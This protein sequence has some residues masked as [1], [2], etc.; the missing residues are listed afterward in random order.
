MRLIAWGAVLG[1]VGR[2]LAAL[3]A[4]ALLVWFDWH[5]G[6]ANVAA[7]VNR[8]LMIAVVALLAAAPWIARPFLGPVAP[9]RT[10]RLIRAGGY[11]MVY[12]LLAVVVA[13]SRFAGSRFDHQV[14]MDQAFHDAE[15]R[16]QAII[17]FAIVLA[18]F[19][20]YAGLVLGVTSRRLAP[21]PATLARA[22]ASGALCA[23]AG[24][25]LMPLGNPL[26]LGNPILQAGY[27][28]TLILLPMGLLAVGARDGIAAG[29]WAGLT[30][31]PLTAVFT[32]TTM[33]L[34]PR[35][36]DLIW[37][38]P[39]PFA[40]HGT[41]FEIQMTIG[42]TAAKYQIGL[43]LGPVAGLFFGGLFS[44]RVESSARVPATDGGGS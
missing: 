15:V 36:V 43:L 8:A 32:V 25:A 17:G 14:V 5:P 29:L 27:V 44:G 41:P 30:A 24:Y 31:A 34:F 21:P 38:N 33:L 1:H 42:D 13:V 2:A 12:G 23:L 11:L 6:S 9:D 28:I 35:H 37:A 18:L 19:G 10:T 40:P 16:S 20:G 7:P 4:G 22:T 39:S 26:H 3:A